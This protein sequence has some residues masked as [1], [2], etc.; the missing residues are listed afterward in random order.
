MINGS[1]IESVAFAWNIAGIKLQSDRTQL[2]SVD[3][4][5]KGW[6]SGSSMLFPQ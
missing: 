1:I 3:V 6:S 4:E 2:K 5:M